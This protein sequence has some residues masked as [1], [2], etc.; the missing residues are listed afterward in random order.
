MT[1][2][3]MASNVSTLYKAMSEA[4]PGDTIQL[5][6]GNYGDCF[7]KNVPGSTTTFANGINI[8]SADIENPAI[9]TGL[10]VLGAQ[11]LTFDGIVFDYLFASGDESWTSPFGFY[12]TEGLTIRNCVF[13]GDLA[14]GVSAAEDG[15]GFGIGAVIRGS[16][17]VVFNNNEMFNFWK[18][19]KVLDSSEVVMSGNDIHSMR[20]DGIN[21]SEVDGITIENNYIHDFNRTNL[22]W[23][24]CDFIQSWTAN[25]D[26]PSSDIVIRSNT[27][28]IGD[29]D[30]TQ[31]IFIGNTLVDQGKAGEEMYF[32]NVKIEDNLIINGHTNGISLGASVGVVMRNNT[33]VHSDGRDPDGNDLAVEIP[34]ISV[35]P[36][37]Q[38]VVVTGNIASEIRIDTALHT[39]RPDWTVANNVL[40]QD[41]D[42]TAPNHYSAVFVSSTIDSHDFTPLR[43]GPAG[44]M[45]AAMG[46][47]LQIQFHAGMD[48]MNT[49]ARNFDATTSILDY[50]ALPHDTVYLWN[51]GDGT[52]AKGS[53]VD[54]VFP[55]SGSYSVV[56]TVKVPGGPSAQITQ[57]VLLCDP[58]LVSYTGGNEVALTSTAYGHIDLTGAESHDGITLNGESGPALAIPRLAL[59]DLI[60][61]DNFAIDVGMTLKDGTTGGVFRFGRDIEA[62]VDTNGSL[63]VTVRSDASDTPIVLRTSNVDLADN[64]H[65][66]VSLRLTDGQLEIWTDGRLADSG[67][68]DGL[69]AASGNHDFWLGTPWGASATGMINTFTI[70]AGAEDFKPIRA[71]EQSQETSIHDVTPVDGAFEVVDNELA[72]P[73]IDNAVVWTPVLDFDPE[74]GFVVRGQDTLSSSNDLESLSELG[75]KLN[76]SGVSAHI[77]RGIVKDLSTSDGFK[78]AFT[79]KSET[80]ASAGQLFGIGGSVSTYIDGSGNLTVRV[81]TQDHGTLRFKSDHV[82]ISD[83][84]SRDVVMT[85]DREAEALA[86]TVDGDKVIDVL[87]PSKI[88]TGNS[89]GLVFG[90]SWGHKNFTGMVEH[91][92]I[93]NEVSDD[94]VIPDHYDTAQFHMMVIED[95][96]IM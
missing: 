45:G 80:D 25:S 63:I 60:T 34:R 8:V 42:P 85:Y 41:Q 72:P 56:L 47:G 20:M 67:S 30:A 24:H 4:K 23:D 15:F 74:N 59:T 51:F 76:P 65:H 5:A 17:D 83:G 87:L 77:S 70:T 49:A 55:D 38:N 29:G 35:S 39:A 13:D 2:L 86:V 89:Q 33:V 75:L 92:S 31:S 46:D 14:Q 43:D 22:S 6:G 37:S 48:A 91:F 66:Q 64:Q 88:G 28:D 62:R 93:A 50:A 90:N 10:N 69:L 53:K 84:T 7:L 26:R 68:M 32:R 12:D 61:A 73:Q 95:A 58:T 11:D 40:V 81:M 78:I 57:Q 71:G 18:G 27:L 3:L 52:T 21:F 1:S 19:I 16:R 94:P 36:L 79:I 82:D 9:F 44:G 96:Y 54:H